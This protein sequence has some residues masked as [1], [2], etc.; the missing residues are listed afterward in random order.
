MNLWMDDCQWLSCTP[1]CGPQDGSNVHHGFI[2]D[3]YNHLLFFCIF[4]EFTD[5]T[6]FVLHV[7]GFQDSPVVASKSIV[8]FLS[9]N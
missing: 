8:V 6:I 7:F 2:F 5:E 1:A 3:V 9:I 4:P